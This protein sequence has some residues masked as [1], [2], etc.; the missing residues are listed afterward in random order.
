MSHAD[1]TPTP[2]S[3]GRHASHDPAGCG[4]LERE[5]VTLLPAAPTPGLRD[6]IARDQRALVAPAWG[7]GLVRGGLERLVWAVG[8]GLAATVVIG[9][10]VRDGAAEPKPPVVAGIDSRAAGEPAQPAPRPRPPLVSEERLGWADE[11]VR[12]LD[13]TTPARV[14]RRFVIERHR[15]PEGLTEVQVPREDLIFLPVALR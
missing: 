8:G 13:N 4:P 15:D 2:D 5:L 9:L 12:F 10:P 7:R 6:R 11:G 14:L 1:H 3:H